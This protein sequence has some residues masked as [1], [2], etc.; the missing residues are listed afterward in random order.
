MQHFAGSDGEIEMR[1]QL[2]L[3]ALTTQIDGA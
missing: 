1:E 3:I 2:A